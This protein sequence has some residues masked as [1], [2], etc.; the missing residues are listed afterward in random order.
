MK[1]IAPA[2]YRRRLETAVIAGVHTAEH[3]LDRTVC[4]TSV[5]AIWAAGNAGPVTITIDGR[6]L[7]HIDGGTAGIEVE[8][9]TRPE[10][11]DAGRTI[12]V[13]MPTAGMIEIQGDIE[14]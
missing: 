7:A 11:V 13:A 14:P 2:R 10:P 5:A 3:T 8:R 9:F 4:L 12:T 6:R 1:T